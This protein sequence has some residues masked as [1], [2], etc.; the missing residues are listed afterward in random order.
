MGSTLCVVGGAA[1]VDWGGVGRHL[2]LCEFHDTGDGID[3][4][5]LVS[6]EVWRAVTGNM[7]SGRLTSL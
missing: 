1:L 3:D 4:H 2:V 6:G 5:V 7:S